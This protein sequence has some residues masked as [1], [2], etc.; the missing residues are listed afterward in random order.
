[1]NEISNMA[2]QVQVWLVMYA[3]HVL[4]MGN[5]GSEEIS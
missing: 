1:M 4:G 2:G 5:I 3:L